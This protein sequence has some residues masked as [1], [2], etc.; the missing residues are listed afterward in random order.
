MSLDLY[1][2]SRSPLQR[3]CLGSSWWTARRT[4]HGAGGSAVQKTGA[5]WV[6]IFPGGFIAMEAL[7]SSSYFVLLITCCANVVGTKDSAFDELTPCVASAAVG[8]FLHWAW[9]WSNWLWSYLRILWPGD[10]KSSVPALILR[11]FPGGGAGGAV[12]TEHINMMTLSDYTDLSGS[13]HTRVSPGRLSV[14]LLKPSLRPSAKTFIEHFILHQATSRVWGCQSEQDPGDSAHVWLAFWRRKTDSGQVIK[15]R[16][17]WQ[18]STAAGKLEAR[19]EPGVPES[20]S[21][22]WTFEWG[23]GEDKPIAGVTLEQGC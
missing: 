4:P 12:C 5:W 21:R 1:I 9:L 11:L 14:T 23:D 20:K 18:V 19:K 22:V 3:L 16:V 8:L 13:L 15:T 10:Q 2:P 6:G 17:C 7:I